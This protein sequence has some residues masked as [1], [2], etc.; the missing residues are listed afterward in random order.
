MRMTPLIA[1]SAALSLAGTMLTS[2]SAA[3]AAERAEPTVTTLARGLAG[4]LS[5]A[6]APDGTRYFTDNFA[7]LLYKQ[8]PGG[9]PTVIYKG[10]KQAEVGA[11][12][13]VGGKLRFAVSEGNNAKGKVWTLDA[14]GVPVLVANIGKHEKSDNP[15]GTVRYGFKSLSGSCAS[16]VPEYIPT[17]YEGVKETH[18][19]ATTT[20]GDVTYVADAAANAIFSV[21]A[22]GVVD[23]V[24]VVPPASVRVTAAA[25]EANGLPACTIG[26]VYRFESVPTDVEVGPDGRLYVTSL[27]GGP[28]DG[29]LGAQGRVLKVNPSTGRVKTLVS[30]LVSPTGLAVSATGDLYVAQLFMG[31]ISRIKAGSTKVRPYVEVPLPADVEVTST[32]LV[33]TI[34][35]LSGRKPKGQVVQITP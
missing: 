3:P 13:A 25:A 27:P 30:G 19:Y 34:K 11:V 4:P 33:A 23:T 31:V 18:P 10:P 21:S 5:V 2:A 12:S 6:V 15:D 26:K 35:A 29:S 9:Q 20:V 16:Q 1:A 28:E 7:G 32:G 8:V 17:A 22:A 14:S 24:A